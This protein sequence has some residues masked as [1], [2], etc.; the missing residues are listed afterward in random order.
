RNSLEVTEGDME[1]FTREVKSIMEH[2]SILLK[3]PVNIRQ[4]QLLYSLV[5]EEFPTYEEIRN[6][7]PKLTWIFYLS[8][9]STSPE[10]LLGYLHGVEWNTIQ[11]TILRW[12]EAFSWF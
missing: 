8:S 6:G 3:D 5:F 7:T 11:S 12:K 4:Q 2:P 9:E 10:S 1:E